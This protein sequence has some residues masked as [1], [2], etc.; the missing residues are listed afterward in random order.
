MGFGRAG[1]AATKKPAK[2]GGCHLELEVV[3]AFLEMKSGFPGW[4]TAGT[5][6][7]H[8]QAGR[9]AASFGWR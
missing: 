9:L 1:N 7:V 5:L 8:K 2:R 6:Q 4:R 3:G